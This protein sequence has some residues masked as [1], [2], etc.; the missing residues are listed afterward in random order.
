MCIHRCLYADRNTSF[1]VSVAVILYSASSS[2][3]PLTLDCKIVWKWKFDGIIFGDSNFV[4]SR[5]F[6]LLISLALWIAHSFNS[7]FCVAIVWHVFLLLSTPRLPFIPH[8]SLSLSLVTLY[9]IL[10][11]VY[12]AFL[13]PASWIFI[14]PSIPI[15]FFFHNWKYNYFTTCGSFFILYKCIEFICSY[16][17]KIIGTVLVFIV[18]GN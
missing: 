7:F 10:F 13:H 5:D 3:F 4:N 15:I 17:W 18:Y 2:S 9:Q 14:P 1:P 8:L 6:S 16:G 12:L 11:L